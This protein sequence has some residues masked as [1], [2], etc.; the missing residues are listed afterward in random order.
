M[1]SHLLAK[2][3]ATGRQIVDV[4]PERAGWTHVGFR[5]L[6]LAAGEVET[7]DTGDRELCIVVLTGR[8]DVKAG[9]QH[10]E[11]LGTR[12]SVFDE[13]SPAAV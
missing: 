4:T 10:F 9:G 8:V 13:R 5:A 1:P 12:D 11:S 7:L 6:R 3:S 2:A